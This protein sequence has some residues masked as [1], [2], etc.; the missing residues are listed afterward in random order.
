M[1]DTEGEGIVMRCEPMDVDAG[2]GRS[3]PELLVLEDEET[4]MDRARPREPRGIAMG[5]E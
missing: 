2:V 1:G 3:E 5:A 4:D